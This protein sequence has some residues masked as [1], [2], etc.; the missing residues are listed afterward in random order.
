MARFGQYCPLA[1]AIE[2]VGDRWSML[3]V[4]DLLHGPRGFNELHRC[5]PRI[6]RTVLAQRLRHLET[7]GI[8]HRSNR[9]AGKVVEYTLTPAGRDLDG[10]LLA[11]GE[12]S[13]R[14]TFGDPSADQLD[15][16]TLAFRMSEQVQ[17]DRLPP[18][19]TVV[20]VRTAEPAA[21]NWLVLSPHGA[22][23][24]RIDPGDEP[25]LVVRGRTSDLQRWF[26][27]REPFVGAV[28]R[29]AISLDGGRALADAF[30]GWFRPA[31]PW[32]DLIGAVARGQGDDGSTPSARG[33][34]GRART[35]GGTGR[36]TRQPRESR[37][38]P[39]RPPGR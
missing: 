38:E 24:C 11:L 28:A 10:P 35:P 1:V 8:V 12:W 34:R 20:E 25:D 27:G 21:R 15:P 33:A 3:I 39:E 6:S 30:P 7:V 2:T 22:T 29:G 37:T 4:R 26:I 23:A 13:V 17:L 18:G 14:W 36:R 16:A 9:G 5:L 31:T 19:R 32:H